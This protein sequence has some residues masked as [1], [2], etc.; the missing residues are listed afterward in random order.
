MEMVRITIL[1]DS[2]AS[3]A[4]GRCQTVGYMVSGNTKQHISH[5]C[6]RFLDDERKWGN[7]A[8]LSFAL[9]W[10]VDGNSGRSLQSHR[11]LTPSYIV[12]GAGKYLCRGFT[13]YS[14]GQALFPEAS[15]KVDNY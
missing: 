7:V 2:P 6:F 12:R 1:G 4:G 14:T 15:T 9:V 11:N 13:Q 8:Q 3:V 10:T 5:F